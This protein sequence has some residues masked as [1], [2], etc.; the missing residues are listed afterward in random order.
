MQFTVGHKRH[1]GGDITMATTAVVYCKAK[2]H[3]ALLAA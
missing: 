3:K 1:L 2:R